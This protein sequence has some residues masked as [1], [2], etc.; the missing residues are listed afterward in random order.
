M[1]PIIEASLEDSQTGTIIADRTWQHLR[2]V[3][4]ADILVHTK[5]N[6]QTGSRAGNPMLT[7]TLEVVDGEFK[8]ARI[9]GHNVM[10]GGITSKDA[11]MP[12]RGYREFV[13]AM[14]T[15]GVGWQCKECGQAG[16]Q[17]FK[18]DKRGH[19]V[20]PDCGKEGRFSTNTDDWNGKLLNGLCT[21]GKFFNSDEPRNELSRVQP[22]GEITEAASAA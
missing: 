4:G 3:E 5:G 10:L 13:N 8:G 19:M 1:P 20:C 18:R 22:Y 16:T 12:I 11:A 6:P 14:A 21:T 2:I 7:L 17:Q 15:Q 9:F